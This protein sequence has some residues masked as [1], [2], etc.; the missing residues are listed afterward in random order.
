LI[1]LNRK[2]TTCYRTK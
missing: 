1:G 2:Y